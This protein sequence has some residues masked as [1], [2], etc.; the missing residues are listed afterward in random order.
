MNDAMNSHLQSIL[1]IHLHPDT[2]TAYWLEKQ[3]A[4]G[5]SILDTIRQVEDL[6]KLGPFDLQAMRERPVEDFVPQ[7][8]VHSQP[9]IIG[10]TGG[11]TGIPKTT[12]WF[13]DDLQAAFIDPFLSNTQHCVDFSQGHWLWLGPSGPHVIG[14]V[15]RQIALATTG[16]D[17]FSVDFDPRWFRAL[18]EGSIARQRYLAHLVTQASHIIEQQKIRYLFST[19]A[20][21]TALAARMSDASK[22]AILFVYLG[23]MSIDPEVL[24]VLGDAFPNADFLSGYGNTLFGVSHELKPHRP[25]GTLPVYQPASVR[26]QL[27]VVSMDENL[28]DAQRL[29]RDVPYGERGQVVMSRFDPSCLL[30]NVMERDSAIRVHGAE[31]A[32]DAAMHPQ[33][34]NHQA[35]KVTS[36]IY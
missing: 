35:F 32:Q 11:A 20:A 30:I 31:W 1:Q 21:L 3:E 33:T 23:G 19:P 34:I 29:L 10:E 26:L 22:Q 28:S 25:D 36:G 24:A 17:G 7:G 8:L 2:G 27:R 15:A 5:F 14:K 18:A 16:C 13:Q 4:L 9:L 12:P 6:P